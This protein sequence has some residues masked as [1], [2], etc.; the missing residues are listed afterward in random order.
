MY[1][2]HRT[3]TSRGSTVNKQRTV[4]QRQVLFS[5]Q[6][7]AS[8]SHAHHSSFSRCHSRGCIYLLPFN[9]QFGNNQSACRRKW[10][11]QTNKKNKQQQHFMFMWDHCCNSTRWTSQQ[12]VTRKTDTFLEFYL[13]GARARTHNAL[14]SL[15]NA[16]PLSLKSRREKNVHG[17]EGNVGRRRLGRIGRGEALWSPGQRLSQA[18]TDVSFTDEY[19]HRVL[20]IEDRANSPYPML[21]PLFLLF[22]L[23]GVYFPE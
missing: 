19:G 18:H 21:R 17:W 10:V 9:L 2:G 20:M 8:P 16:L 14:A 15:S 12:E 4:S 11:K 6:A 23:Q 7:H 13:V 1:K 5:L 3:V 22:F